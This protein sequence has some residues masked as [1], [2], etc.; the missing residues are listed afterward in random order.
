MF[1]YLLV[2]CKFH[3][4]TNRQILTLFFFLLKFILLFLYKVVTG[5]LNEI[6]DTR[7]YEEED[8]NKI[9]DKKK[10]LKNKKKTK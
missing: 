2:L 10:D 7:D 8:E 4:L 6:N 3:F 5:Q 9:E 1:R